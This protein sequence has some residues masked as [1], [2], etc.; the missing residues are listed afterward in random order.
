MLPLVAGAAE[1][2]TCSRALQS[3]TPDRVVPD[4]ASPAR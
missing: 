3:V 1:R 4:R 2:G